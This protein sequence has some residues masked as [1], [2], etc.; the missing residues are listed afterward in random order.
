MDSAVFCHNRNMFTHSR[1]QFI[2]RSADC[3]FRMSLLSVV[4]RQAASE[5][6]RVGM[7]GAAGRAGSLNISL[8]A[9]RMP[10]LFPSR[11]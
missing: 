9:T 4:G 8:L 1:R 11:D 10:R 6:I 3:R 7:V 5:R 2:A